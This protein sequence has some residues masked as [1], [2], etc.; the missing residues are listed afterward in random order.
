ML[1][2]AASD[3]PQYVQNQADYICDGTADDVEIQAALDALG[4]GT[5]GT[6][7][8][9]GGTY[10]ISSDLVYDDNVNL[11]ILAFGAVFNLAASVTGLRITQAAGHQGKGISVYGLEINGGDNATTKGVE[12]R[13]S[14]RARF[15]D[16]RIDDCT[17]GVYIN[18]T[19]SLWSETVTMTNCFISSCSTAGVHFA[20]D[21]GTGSYAQFHGWAL[22]IRDCGTGV[23]ADT[24]ANVYRSRIFGH[25]WVEPGQT[26]VSLDGGVQGSEFHISMEAAGESGN[27]TGWNIGANANNTVKMKIVTHFAGSFSTE[28]A[29]NGQQFIFEDLTGWVNEWRMYNPGTLEYLKLFKDNEANPILQ[30]MANYAD[31][32]SIE[33]GPGGGTAPDTTIR[34]ANGGGVEILQDSNV[35]A[36]ISAPTVNGHTALEIAGQT[37]GSDA[38]ERVKFGSNNTGPG[39]SGRALYID[40]SA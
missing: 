36:R 31:G 20:V 15:Y 4:G 19:D 34:R 32:G 17:D 7:V 6:L 38:L 8:L 28:V 9:T 3:A 23:L 35:I 16:C 10:A 1:T 18:S 2:V 37:S 27:R 30:L 24:G 12:V 39:S 5:S 33:L 25:V 26:G 11:T 29:A 40:N 22:N 14:S 13:N 21:G